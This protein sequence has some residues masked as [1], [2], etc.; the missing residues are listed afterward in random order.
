MLQTRDRR[1]NVFESRPRAKKCFFEIS[2]I[3]NVE[4]NLLVLLLWLCFIDFYSYIYANTIRYK[5]I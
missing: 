1:L 5:I 3:E 4:I 2:R